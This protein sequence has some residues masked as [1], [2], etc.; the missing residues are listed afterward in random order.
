MSEI[1]VAIPTHAGRE[2][3]LSRALDSAFAQTLPPVAVS[4]A[5]DVSREGSAATRNRALA[6]VQTP[7]V[8]FLDSDDE[9]LPQHL[10]LL[11]ACANSSSADVVYSIPEWVGR[12]PAPLRFGLPFDAA[13]LRLGNY[14]PVTTL[15][16]T[17]PVKAAGGFQCPPGSIF[18]DWGAWIAMLD[19]GAKFVHLPEVTWRWH[20]HPGQTAGL[21]DGLRAG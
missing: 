4:V 19:A 12:E 10:E 14:I 13:A 5:V 9:F 21:K 7:W 16:R 20:W 15:A 2:K 6:A 1:T 18:D 3:M 11:T 17:E 8:A